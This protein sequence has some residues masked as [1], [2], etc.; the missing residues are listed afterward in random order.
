VIEHLSQTYASFLDTLLQKTHSGPSRCKAEVLFKLE[1]MVYPDDLLAPVRPEMVVGISQRIAG[2]ALHAFRLM[3]DVRAE[4]AITR[5][6]FPEVDLS[7]DQILHF[8]SGVRDHL[9]L[10]LETAKSARE[11]I[12]KEFTVPTVGT[13]RQVAIPTGNS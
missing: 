6:N 2:D 13:L 9:N 12:A 5:K 8:T 7:I 10:A 3:H 1:M 11:G 4:I